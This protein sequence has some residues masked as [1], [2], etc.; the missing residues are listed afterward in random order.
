VKEDAHVL[1]V[2]LGAGHIDADSKAPLGA[3]AVDGNAGHGELADNELIGGAELEL[4]E[5]AVAVDVGEARVVG[6]CVWKARRDLERNDR[7]LGQRDRARA[8]ERRV[9]DRTFAAARGCRRSST[10]T[11]SHVAAPRRPASRATS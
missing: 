10:T 3:Q 6:E 4:K 11:K 7:L 8:S 2:G 5:R 9:S 1:D